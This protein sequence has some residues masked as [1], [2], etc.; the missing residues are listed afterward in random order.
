M[1]KNLSQKITLFV[2]LSFCATF[3]EQTFGSAYIPPEYIQSAE[4]LSVREMFFQENSQNLSSQK[5][6]FYL[7][8]IQIRQSEIKRNIENNELFKGKSPEKAL[9]E[10]NN[11][12]DVLAYGF[13]ISETKKFLD[14]SKESTSS[15]SKVLSNFE[16]AQRIL[17]LDFALKVEG[18]ARIIPTT[19]HHI[20]TSRVPWTLDRDSKKVQPPLNLW[21]PS[22]GK[23]LSS[24][25]VLSHPDASRLNPKS[26]VQAWQETS[27]EQIDVKEHFEKGQNDLY[28]GLK[29]QYPNESVFHLKS[30][31]KSQTKPKL[32][33]Y[34]IDQNGKKIPFRVKLSREI[35]SEITSSALSSALG[36]YSDLSQTRSDVKVYLTDIDYQTLRT[37]WNSYYDRFDIELYMKK[38]PNGQFLQSDEQQRNFVVFKQAAIEAR[39]EGVE[40][41]G[42]WPYWKNGH[43]SM[44][45]VRGLMLYNMWINNTD[46]KEQE[47]NKLLMREMPNGERKYFAMQ[48]DQGFGFGTIL[49]EL[50]ESFTWS[51]IRNPS[52]DSRNVYFRYRTF[53]DLTGQKHISE[54][55]M[56]WA[57][58]L[59]A[60]LSRKQI[61]DA[62]MLGGW[63]KSVGLLLAEKLIS[64]RNELV[65]AFNLEAEGIRMIPYDRELSTPDGIVLKGHLKQTRFDDF[66]HEF[67]F[68]YEFWEQFLVDPLKEALISGTQGVIGTLSKISVDP[69]SVG[70]DPTHLAQVIMQLKREVEKN[71]TPRSDSEAYV[72]QDTLKI[73]IELGAG[74]IVGGRAQYTLTYHLLYP[75]KTREGALTD[76]KFLANL[77]LPVEQWESDFPENSILISEVALEGGGFFRTDDFSELFPIGLQVNLSKILLH[78]SIISSRTPGK[79]HLYEDQSLYNEATQKIYARLGFLKIPIQKMSY[80]DGKITRIGSV[81]ERSQVENDVN[82]KRLFR[83]AIKHG[84]IAEL[85]GIVRS[86]ELTS[87]FKEKQFKF[88]LLGMISSKRQ[89]RIDEI[90]KMEKEYGQKEHKDFMTSSDDPLSLYNIQISN[91]RTNAW[92]FLDDGEEFNRRIMLISEP[93]SRIGEIRNPKI[94][95]SYT[96]DDKDTKTKELA[97]KY[98]LF[99]NSTA[100]G[101]ILQFT[102]EYHTINGLWGR[103]HTYVNVIYDTAAVE[104]ILT[105]LDLKKFQKET[106]KIFDHSSAYWHYRAARRLVKNIEKAREM[107]RGVKQMEL[108]TRGLAA[109]VFKWD[110]NLQGQVLGYMNYLISNFV[111]PKG[112]YIRASLANDG[113]RENIFP[114]GVPASGTW[115]EK[116]SFP[117]PYMML[118]DASPVELFKSL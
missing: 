36:F 10:A 116:P 33:T 55:D 86:F 1:Q 52:K 103:T 2:T 49:P 90:R 56:K 11:D 71:P 35:H 17:E 111:G 69:V 82:L 101:P 42:S 106:D 92:T 45:E 83:R 12:E 100:S 76:R 118:M 54:A 53:Q 74:L 89:V 25:E 78:R 105:G 8:Q 20:I 117:D 22:S 4:S 96:I 61:T 3:T 108:L 80:A 23:F 79:L 40:R 95:F 102:P 48:H 26:L 41:V 64:R 115:G 46:V 21:N 47:N 58:R 14:F 15:L 113:S 91:N 98:I 34:I 68:G 31:R 7:T 97:Q 43:A 38:G 59:I 18:N 29:I 87:E 85:E 81:M 27:I 73:G 32:N 30:V 28:S 112:I 60:R 75:S 94:Q 66:P 24:Q 110:G 9:Q 37:E 77:L 19:A 104:W 39:V 62:V 13:L 107:P 109:S 57:A 65:E 5:I 84:K 63:P 6:E 72:V 99:A 51:M 114:A 16:Q 44:R 93:T 50:V 70:L 67:K 88:S